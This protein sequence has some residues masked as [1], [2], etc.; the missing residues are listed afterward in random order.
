[1][2]FTPALLQENTI[3]LLSLKQGTMTV[4]EYQ[5]KFFELL[6]F[7][8]QINANSKA[9]YDHF[10]QGLNQEIFG[11]ATVCDDLTSYEGLVNRCHLVD[12]NLTR[13]RF[14][15]STR[16]ASSLGPRAQSFKNSSSTSSLGSGSV[17]HFC[18]KKGQ[19]ENCGRD[20]SSSQCRRAA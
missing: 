7:A 20:H 19:C 17:Y 6:S 14:I 5:Q 8:L 9:K 4:D 2:Y 13:G 12:I 1:M 10:L 18:W 3:E 15:L 16:P 11:R